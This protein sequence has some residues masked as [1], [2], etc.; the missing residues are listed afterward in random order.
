MFVL[1]LES[2]PN[3]PLGLVR[4][5]ALASRASSFVDGS[6]CGCGAHSKVFQVRLGFDF[7]PGPPRTSLLIPTAP[8]QLGLCGELGPQGTSLCALPTARVMRE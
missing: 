7:Y 1:Y 4:G 2:Q 3:T 5:C 8:R 6:G